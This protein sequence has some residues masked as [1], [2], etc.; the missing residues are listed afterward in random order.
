MK[1]YLLI[2]LVLFLLFSFF[3]PV[4]SL[5]LSSNPSTTSLVSWWSLDE[6]SGTRNDSHGSNHLTDNNTVG[7][8]SGIKSNAASF[9]SANS[10]YLSISDNASISMGDI[11]F[12]I[13]SWVQLKG[14]K[15]AYPIVDKHTTATNQREYYLLYSLSFDR[16]T[17]T[18]SSNGT[19]QEFVNADNL[20]SPSIDTWY[21]VCAWHDSV[22]NT[23]NIQVNN[24]SVNSVSHSSGVFN[25][26]SPLRLGAFIT[27]VFSNGYTDETIIYKKVLNSDERTWLY[28]SGAG[29]EYCEVANTCATPTPT[30]TLTSTIT[31]TPEFTFTPSFTPS[32]TYTVT[33]VITNTP[34]SVVQGVEDLFSFQMQSGSFQVTTGGLL[35]FLLLLLSGT[36]LYKK[37]Q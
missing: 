32:P 26:T 6:V 29:R 34:D 37:V 1:R 15:A 21:M 13:C 23:I 24:G 33:P 16:F 4:Y 19:A 5:P 35:V 2:I 30:I 8:A 11:D 12:T 3:T 22:S 20:G 25:G 36:Y 9:V 31:N 18:V 17:F 14:S 28:N 27:S 10:E 7:S